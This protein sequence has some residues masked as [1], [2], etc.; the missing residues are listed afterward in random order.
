MVASVVPAGQPQS[1]WLAHDVAQKPFVAQSPS[2]HF[3]LA[4]QVSPNFAVPPPEA[5]SLE[6]P[7]NAPAVTP[8]TSTAAQIRRIPKLLN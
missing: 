7:L 4:L 1:L 2:A 3:T 8:K 6:H 5:A